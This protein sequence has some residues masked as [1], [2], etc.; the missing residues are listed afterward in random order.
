MNL[1]ISTVLNFGGKENFSNLYY[2]SGSACQLG[3]I[4]NKVS[5][6]YKY[7]LQMHDS[8]YF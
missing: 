3:V 2:V 6:K 1:F 7:F 4:T 5:S 8:H